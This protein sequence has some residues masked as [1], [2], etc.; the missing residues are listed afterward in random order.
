[1]N[2]TTY[3]DVLQNFAA[4]TLNQLN[5]QASLMNR[6]ESKYLIHEEE[7][8]ELLKMLQE[9]FQ[10]LEIGGEKIFSY[11]NIYMD[12]QDLEFYHAHN[13]GDLAR[14]KMRTRHYLESG[15]SYFEFKQKKGNVMRKFRYDIDVAQH[16]VLDTTAYEFM[17]DVHKS[18]YGEA[19]EKLVFPSL[20]TSY[21]RCT[22]VHKSTAEKITIDFNVSTEQVRNG[23]QKFEMNN[24]V[25]VEFKAETKDSPTK[26]IFD[27]FNL[28]ASKPCSKY[29]LG[30][31]FLGNVKEWGRFKNTID[32]VKTIMY[33]NLSVTKASRKQLKKFQTT[34]LKKLIK[35]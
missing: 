15:L 4:I 34:Q 5:A 35:K 8:G 20:R 29:C 2:K 27:Q 23:N 19:F 1:M 10:I 21:Q 33:S 25:I 32:T 22:L 13:N 11:D 16:G 9:D 7:L 3:Q 17:N 26:Q 31:Y 30:N 28:I 18:L 6:I 14:I 24:L 12:T